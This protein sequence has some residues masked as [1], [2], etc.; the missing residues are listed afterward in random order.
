M[1]YEYFIPS[2]LFRTPFIITQDTGVIKVNS[3]FLEGRLGLTH[4]R[5]SCRPTGT[6]PSP[7]SV[8]EWRSTNRSTS[9]SST[10]RPTLCTHWSLTGNTAQPH[11]AVTSGRRWLVYMPLC[12]TVVTGKGSM[13][14]VVVVYIR[15]QESASLI[16]SK[17]TAVLVTPESGLVQE[18]LLMTPTRVETLPPLVLTMETKTPRPWVTSWCSKTELTLKLKKTRRWILETKIKL[19][20]WS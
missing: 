20:Y 11:W 12:K 17:M 7:R 3:T 14:C 5:L 13:L 2:L 15:K 4:K 6:H 18:G 10:S 1:L 19:A 8:L 16:T 9:L